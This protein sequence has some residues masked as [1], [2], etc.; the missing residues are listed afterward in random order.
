MSTG[1]VDEATI[2]VRAGDGGD[3]SASFHKEKH[4]PKGRPDGGDGGKGGSVYLEA[5]ANLHTLANYRFRRMHRAESGSRA[6]GNGRH[7]A[8][9]GDLELPVPVGTVVRDHATGDVLAD[10][11]VAGAR[12]EVARGGRGGRG[13]IALAS[14]AN[15]APDFAERGEDGEEVQIDLE[16]RLVA[17]IGL[18]GSPNAGKSTLLASLSA[19][20]PKVADYP[21]TTLE[22]HLG[23]V[24][25]ADRRFV[26]ADLPGLI[27]G[28]AE[29]RGLGTRFLRHTERCALLAA[30]VDLSVADPVSEIEAVVSEVRAHDPGLAERVRVVIGTKTDLEGAGRGA[31]EVAAWARERGIAA[32]TVCAPLDEGL[33]PLL[34]VLEAEVARAER[35]RPPAE[36]FALYRPVRADHVSV[37]REGGAFRVTSAR[38][39][40][41]VSMTPLANP[42]AVRHLQRRLSSLGVNRALAEAGAAEGDEV[43]IGEAEFEYHPDGS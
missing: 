7:G 8:S 24:E 43:R 33:G 6:S 4:R 37:Q 35:E 21:F 25:R 28:A 10:L 3:G 42:R 36:T 14:A 17:D 5:D 38:V 41:L 26:I 22:P 12:Y 13:N 20:R 27:E 34:D 1:F 2:W 39:E 30:V 9:G 23:V 11:A 18:L 16:L 15:R 29:G 19:A 40:R 31:D 32:V